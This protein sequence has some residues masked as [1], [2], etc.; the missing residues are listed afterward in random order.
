M[1]TTMSFLN[2]TLKKL[3]VLGYLFSATA[4]AEIVP[5]LNLNAG[6]RTFPL[7]G[8]LELSAGMGQEIWG[9]KKNALY[10]FH[11][12]STYI[13]GVTDFFATGWR[14]EIFPVSILGI[15]MGQNFL[16]SHLDY[17]DY[18]C[19]LYI[20]RGDY[21][22]QFVEVPL[23][24]KLWRVVVTGSFRASDWV[25][26]GGDRAGA[27]TEF[28]EP[29]SGLHLGVNDTV[30]STDQDALKTTR[31]RVGAFYLFQDGNKNQG[32]RVGWV[33]SRYERGDFDSD[34]ISESVHSEQWMGV[35][36]YGIDL[37]SE[38]ALNLML[39]AG[40]YHSDLFSVQ[41][42]Y[43]AALSWQIRP[44]LGY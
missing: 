17:E 31:L 16:A 6:T 11:R 40:E 20:C 38:Q 41:P 23:F 24:L 29:E 25:W 19:S 43:M 12:I 44:K 42:S 13:E 5:D 26:R 3:L 7:A 32:W 33:Y 39:G 37:G 21:E 18:D 30:L 22:E 36:S 15:R 9:S 35:V 2:A 27:V 28:I 4:Q 1:K 8:S 14:Y 34:L 10:G